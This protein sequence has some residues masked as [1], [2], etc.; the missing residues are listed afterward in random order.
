MTFED[1]FVIL[2]D[3]NDQIY[4]IPCFTFDI[5]FPPMK[6]FA[7]YFLIVLLFA[8]VKMTNGQDYDNDFKQAKSFFN[9]G[10]YE[11]AVTMFS[12]LIPA[13]K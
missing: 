6:P 11:E 12:K 2:S 4:R 7:K 8:S 5:K 9:S 3:N 10:K 13:F 1:I